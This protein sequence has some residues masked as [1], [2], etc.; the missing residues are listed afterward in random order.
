VD[1]SGFKFITGENELSGYQSSA[2]QTKYFCKH[3]GSPIISKNIS[4]PNKVRV[5]LGVIESA[6]T[7]R[8]SAHIFVTSKAHWETINDDLPQY[9]AYEPNRTKHSNNT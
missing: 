1:E 8:P 4:A 6:I 2:D 9:E 7:E 5:R 3:C